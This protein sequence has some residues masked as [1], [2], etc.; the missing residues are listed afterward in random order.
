ME[1]LEKA[2]ITI[3]LSTTVEAIGD[4]RVHLSRQ[5]PGSVLQWKGSLDGVDTVVLAVGARSNTELAEQLKAAETTG[6]L[7][8]CE[9]H[10]IGDSVKPGFAIDAI[11][12]G[13][14]VAREI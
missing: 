9:V 2:G 12:A 10:V 11:Y 1:R 8:V 14:K 13:A 6:A 4:H 5:E 3:L 7:G